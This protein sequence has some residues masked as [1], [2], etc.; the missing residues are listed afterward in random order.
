MLARTL[1]RTSLHIMALSLFFI[2]LFA[3]A[4]CNGL[5]R[6]VGETVE[7]PTISASSAVVI[8]ASTGRVI[9][10]KNAEERRSPASMTKIMTCIL[11]LEV[12]SP[13]DTVVISPSVALTEDNYF[14]WKPGDRITADELMQAMMLVSDNG[15]AVAVA[16]QVSGTVPLFSEKMNKKARELGCKDTNFANPNGLPNPNHFSTAKDMAKI[17]AYA[18]KMEDFR[19]IVDDRQG[20]IQWTRPAGKSE[21]VENTNHLLGN[22]FGATGIK[23]GWTIA[24]GGC[25]AASAKRNGI[26]LIAIVMNS[27][28]SYTR[29]EDAKKLLDY[30]FTQVHSYKALDKNREE[31]KIWVSG[32]TSA[33]LHVGPAEDVVYPLFQGERASHYSI[34]YDLPFIVDAEIKE[35]QKVGELIVKYNDEPVIRIPVTARETV[36]EGFS[37]SS[38]AVGIM[39]KLV[40]LWTAMGLM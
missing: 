8:E 37:L 1:A 4:P 36:P 25:L 11:G 35:G 18:M 2:L 31:R 19:D 28:D 30:G 5:P 32:G 39:A 38:F 20:T 9:Y 23:T 3:P 34:S 6:E 40:P 16:Q 12:L 26:E 7:K 27:E 10:E 22:F 13:E 15:A 17:A 21:E 24:A 14:D 29:F 33:T